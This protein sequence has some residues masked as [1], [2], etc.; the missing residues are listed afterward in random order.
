MVGGGKTG[1][2]SAVGGG[3]RGTRRVIEGGNARPWLEAGGAT[4]R[5]EGRRREGEGG[6]GGGVVAGVLL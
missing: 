5:D 2:R 4:R 6:E 3:G 1:W